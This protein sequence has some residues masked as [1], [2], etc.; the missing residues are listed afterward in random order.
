MSMCAM[1]LGHVRSLPP[2]WR[3]HHDYENPLTQSAKLMSK[4]PHETGDYQFQI[5]TWPTT[6][7]HSFPKQDLLVEVCLTFN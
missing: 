5:F 7:S 2:S 3:S 4:G 6:I 1:G